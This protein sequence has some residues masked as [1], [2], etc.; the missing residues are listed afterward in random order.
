[1]WKVQAC[2]TKTRALW[3]WE[4]S[5]SPPSCGVWR[6]NSAAL[7]A[8]Q[9]R[10]P[11]FSVIHLLINVVRR[12][13]F[14]AT[15]ILLSIWVS[16]YPLNILFLNLCVIFPGKVELLVHV[17]ILQFTFLGNHFSEHKDTEIDSLK[18]FCAH[19]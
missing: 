5:E 8:E 11:Y 1:M 4:R 13:H 15:V 6:W 14:Q 19:V 17:V 2:S 18:S 10:L 7:L 9:A 12:F 3:S 16:K